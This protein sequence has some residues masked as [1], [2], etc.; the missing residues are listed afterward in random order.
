MSDQPT[1]GLTC[2]R[3][4]LLEMEVQPQLPPDAIT[5]F[6]VTGR[7][8]SMTSTASAALASCVEREPQRVE[9]GGKG[10][11]GLQL[12]KGSMGQVLFS[13]VASGGFQANS[14]QTCAASCG[15]KSLL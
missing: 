1:R 10:R 4:K 7:M 9:R 13:G 12:P 5:A 3:L 2:K 8:P 15:A 14:N 11:S 6:Q